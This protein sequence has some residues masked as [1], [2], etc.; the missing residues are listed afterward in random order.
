[1]LSVASAGARRA[2]TAV[3][4]RRKLSPPNT[5]TTALT[6]PA[7]IPTISSV[8]NPFALLVG[9]DDGLAPPDPVELELD[10][11]VDPVVGTAAL[12]GLTLGFPVLSASGAVSLLAVV[13]GGAGVIVDPSGSVI[14]GTTRF[15]HDPN[16]V[17]VSCFP[18]ESG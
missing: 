6:T 16:N 13:P 8:D 9:D 4:T 5:A 7:M 12:E 15:S 10:A 18:I 17:D 14:V 11:P 2:S 3:F 1:M